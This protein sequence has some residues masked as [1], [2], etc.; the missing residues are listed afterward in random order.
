MENDNKFDL[1][2]DFANPE[3]ANV[4]PLADEQDLSDIFELSSEQPYKHS[5][6][7]TKSKKKHTV[8][9]VALGF[10]LAIIIVVAIM[11]EIIVNDYKGSSRNGNIVTVEIP[12][13]AS[14]STIADRLQAAG[15]VDHALLFRV[16]SRLAGVETEY[17]Y[18]T[19][20]F[21]NDIGFEAIAD[22][23]VTQGTKAKTET[24]VIPEGTGIYDYV[25]T[26]NGKDVTIPGIATLLENAGIC[27]KDDFFAALNEVDFETRLLKN[28][29]RTDAYCPLEG[30]LFPDTY[31]FK[32]G[33]SKECAKLAIERMLKKTDEVITDDM[34]KRAEELGYSVN[35]ILTMA[36]IV[37]L[38]AGI[39]EDEMANVAAVFYNRLKNPSSF[40]YLGSSVTV[41]YG[42][43]YASDDDRYC[44]QKIYDKNGNVVKDA[45]KGLPP[46]PICSPGAA[47][48]KAA[49]YPTEG[50][51]K[52]YFVTDSKGS[53]FYSSSEKEHSSIIK[54]LQ[55]GDN[56]I[57]ETYS[58]K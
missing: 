53:F 39:V 29:N 46:G 28:A 48:I 25:K 27:T 12:Q 34:Y 41:Y 13:G 56:W 43:F 9:W 33:N 47:A 11:C 16:Y 6:E 38:E 37:Q 44:T 15:A 51:K 5:A 54:A 14:V 31:D 35:E 36:S 24:V 40:P 52:T 7:P 58:K 50:F 55:N 20:E 17:R 1:Q 3:E 42:S 22:L 10:L 2:D 8:L 18:G 23:L 32:V 49:L 57:Y 30:Y 21:K 19:Y 26:V 45:T 4:E